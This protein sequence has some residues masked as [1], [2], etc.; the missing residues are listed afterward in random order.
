[1]TPGKKG[2]SVAKSM[3][4]K[5][6]KEATL[7]AKALNLLPRGVVKIREPDDVTRILCLHQQ[8]WG[9]KRIAKTL[10]I[11]RNTVK[12]YIRKG[13]WT[14][15]NQPERAGKLSGLECWLKEKLLQHKGNADVVRQELK[16][17]KQIEVSLRTVERAVAA[18]R[19]EQRAAADV[20]VRFETMPGQQIQIDFGEKWVQIGDEKIKV[21]LFVATLG[22]SRRSFV[23]PFRNETQESW[24]EGID[25][26]FRHFGGVP[27]EILID[28]PAAL[29]KT[30]RPQTGE[31]ELNE[32]F[33]ALASYWNFRP[34][35]CA[36]ARARTKGKVERSVGYAKH[37][38]IAGRQ[39]KSWEEMEGHIVWWMREVGD[40]RIHDTTGEK[41][42]E[43]FANNELEE[44]SPLRGRAPFMQIR[45]LT[46]KIH[47]DATV[48]YGRNR[49]SVPWQL[50]G[51][52]AV[53]QVMNGEVII[54][55]LP[56][57]K[58]VARHAECQGTRQRV[59]A[60]GHLG[61]IVRSLQGDDSTLNSE[62]DVA[63]N[64]SLQRPLSE[65]TE[66]AAC[67]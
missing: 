63:E 21:H 64:I 12:K 43:R 31:F 9:T 28:N 27:K 34:I 56:D 53:I 55:I 42:V 32:K 6:P 45:E 30:N 54:R 13:Q 11:S 48:E 51:R 33:K 44:L 61:G 5:T 15:S 26:A 62:T 36:P 29:V 66:A 58:E 41:P 60:R 59:I 17:E 3:Q 8:G 24:F 10:E 19:Q 65:Y 35:A 1:M 7:S 52:D 57:M 4:R 14:K 47:K 37:N 22:Y 46:R 38:C 23:K 39:F 18:Y 20:T 16:S 40:V 50:V 49:Y 25:E 2:V 67:M